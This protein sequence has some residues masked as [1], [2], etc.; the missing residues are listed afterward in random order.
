[1]S[2]SILRYTNKYSPRSSI[3]LKVLAR[4]LSFLHFRRSLLPRPETIQSLRTSRYKHI[5]EGRHSVVMECR[6]M[7]NSG[8][9]V[10]SL[11][12]PFFPPL[13]RFSFLS[14]SS[15]F[16][17]LPPFRYLFSFV[18]SSFLLLFYTLPSPSPSSYLSL[19]LSCR[20]RMLTES[21][22]KL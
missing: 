16:L 4:F 5:Q 1:M 7:G 22:G 17:F 11:T 13:F 9:K 18:S 12:F 10:P 15:F 14:F 6:G 3:H 8:N 19:T 2:T 21:N 20:Q